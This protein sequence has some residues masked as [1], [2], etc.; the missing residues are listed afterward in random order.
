MLILSKGHAETPAQKAVEKFISEHGRNYTVL[1]KNDR[2]ERFFSPPI[3]N[4]LPYF[5]WYVVKIGGGSIDGF[6]IVYDSEIWGA[7]YNDMA[8]KFR[9]HKNNFRIICVE[10]WN[11]KW[12]YT[13][14]DPDGKRIPQIEG[15]EIVP[16]NSDIFKDAKIPEYNIEEKIP[17][18]A[19]REIL[20]HSDLPKYSAGY[21]AGDGEDYC[22]IPGLP[23]TAYVDGLIT[24]PWVPV[25]WLGCEVD[26]GCD[27]VSCPPE[28]LAWVE[29]EDENEM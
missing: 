27:F 22:E 9:L 24:L 4:S 23:R 3:K 21:G 26:D 2:G 25:E 16:G 12:E 6:D 7:S 5:G 1:K 28:L 10:T 18:K 29:E 19:L 11:G 13:A 15:F 20:Y 8:P 17:F 14:I